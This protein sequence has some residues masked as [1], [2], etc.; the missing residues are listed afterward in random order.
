M[1][2]RAAAGRLSDINGAVICHLLQT[3]SVLVERTQGN[4]AISRPFGVRVGRR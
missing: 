1:Q 3:L 4:Y 2:R